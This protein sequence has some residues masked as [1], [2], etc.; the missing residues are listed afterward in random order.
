MKTT[1]VPLTDQQALELHKG[2]NQ[3]IITILEEIYGKDFFYNKIT[4]KIKG[5]DDILKLSGQTL[6]NVIPY[7]EPKNPK[8]IALNGVA[9]SYLFVEVINEGWEPD[10]DNP[11]QKKYEPIFKWNG[12]GF[13]FSRTNCVVTYTNTYV[14]SRL[15]FETAE[16]AEFAARTFIDIYNEHLTKPKI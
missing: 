11:N 2:S 10:Y 6:N 5:F 3:A 4:D 9:K 16:K 13:G 14:G 12:K 7:A 1:Q 8:Q 15:V